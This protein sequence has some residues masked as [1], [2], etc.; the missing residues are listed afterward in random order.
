MKNTISTLGREVLV[1]E[2]HLELVLEVRSGAQTTDDRARSDL[3]GVVDDESVED[4][5]RHVLH[6]ARHRL[7]QDLSRSSVLKMAFFETLRATA[8]TTSSKIERLRWIR[9][10]CPFVIGSK[11]AG[12]K[13]QPM[14][15]VDRCRHSCHHPSASGPQLQPGQHVSP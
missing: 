6:V 7:A 12:N 9:S 14:V 2:R 1:H 5:D 10:R 15:P 11:L 4:L 8:S 13:R 3:L